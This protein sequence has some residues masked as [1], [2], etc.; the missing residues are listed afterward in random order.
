MVGNVTAALTV[1]G[2]DINAT[3]DFKANGTPGI[4]GIADTTTGTCTLTFQEGILT[5]MNG[6]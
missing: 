3:G 4:S 1:T 5:A 2:A 6:C